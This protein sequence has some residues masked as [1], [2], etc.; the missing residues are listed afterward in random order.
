[1]EFVE[2]LI[3]WMINNQKKRNGEKEKDLTMEMNKLNF[4]MIVLDK[5]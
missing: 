1:M 2:L 4:Q 3:E 5:K